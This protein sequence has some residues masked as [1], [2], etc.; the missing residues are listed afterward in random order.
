M[1]RSI[2]HVPPLAITRL[3]SDREDLEPSPP[4]ARKD[5]FSIIT[6]LRDFRLHRLWLGVWL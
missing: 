2:L 5:A 6:Q 4:N 3:S 1:C